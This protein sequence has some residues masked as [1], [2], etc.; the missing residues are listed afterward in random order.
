MKCKNLHERCF[1]SKN[2]HSSGEKQAIMSASTIQHNTKLF[3]L[4]FKPYKNNLKNL[5]I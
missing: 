5:S 1:E 2:Y 3:K 4:L